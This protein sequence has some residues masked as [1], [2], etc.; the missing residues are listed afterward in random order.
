MR[1]RGELSAAGSLVRRTP[2]GRIPALPD[3]QGCGAARRHLAASVRTNSFP[4]IPNAVRTAL[5]GTCRLTNP[6]DCRDFGPLGERSPTAPALAVPSG[7][8][9]RVSSK[10]S[11]K[12]AD[13]DRQNRGQPLGTNYLGGGGNAITSLDPRFPPGCSGSCQERRGSPGL[14]PGTLSNVA[15]RS[16]AIVLSDV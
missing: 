2:P 7:Q 8:A 12:V 16:A 6:S 1:G 5:G 9:L 3:G 14:A 13:P 15:D 10:Q 4:R 11:D